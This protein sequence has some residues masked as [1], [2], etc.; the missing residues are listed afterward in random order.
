MT[1]MTAPGAPQGEG[2]A[3]FT[4]DLNPDSILVRLITGIT[5]IF[6]QGTHLSLHLIFFSI[7][8]RH[9]ETPLLALIC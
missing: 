6:A 1:H 7:K 9:K 5:L 8:K 4:G 2:F 3:V